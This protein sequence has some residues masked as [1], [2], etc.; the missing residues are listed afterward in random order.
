MG[1]KIKKINVIKN[2][3]VFKNFSWDSSLKDDGGN[4]VY[5]K[6]INILYGRNYSGKTTLSRIF[7]AIETGI[8]SDKYISP[9]F[10][11]NF[12]DGEI[13]TYEMLSESNNVIRVFNKD[14]V[15]ENL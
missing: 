5:F 10:T 8:L 3:A 13:V 6:N 1:S 15:S 12:D 4:I 11:I 7:R 2:V 9:E 14:F